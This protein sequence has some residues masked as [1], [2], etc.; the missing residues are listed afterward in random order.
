MLFLRLQAAIYR[1]INSPNAQLLPGF[2]YKTLVGAA[3]SAIVCPLLGSLWSSVSLLIGH[4][5]RRI[6]NGEDP[7]RSAWVPIGQ[8][9]NTT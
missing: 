7:R 3:C 6:G 2:G 8:S 4:L 5:R 1:P 9:L